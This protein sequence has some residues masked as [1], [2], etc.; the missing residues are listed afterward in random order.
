MA[1]KHMTMRQRSFEHS[2]APP[3]YRMVLLTWA[4]AFPVLNVLHVL[5]G[6]Q[7]AALP[8]PARTLLLTGVLITLLTYVIMP[9]LT[10]WCADWLLAPSAGGGQDAA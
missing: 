3:R 9:R 6:Q 4:A 1:I 10:R 8:L 2:A 5:F 7:L